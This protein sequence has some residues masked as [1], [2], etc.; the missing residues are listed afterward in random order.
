MPSPDLKSP[1]SAVTPRAASWASTAATVGLNPLVSMRAPPDLTSL[2]I[3]AGR[4]FALE[5]RAR[6]VPAL[7]RTVLD[8]APE[9]PCTEAVP[10]LRATV[11]PASRETWLD[12]APPMV[13]VPEFIVRL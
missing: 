4:K 10:P 2:T 12:S 5:A 11:P 6:N 1:P 3:A 9:N 8:A 13:S 7:K